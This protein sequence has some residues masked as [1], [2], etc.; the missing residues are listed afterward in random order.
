MGLN[1]IEI[2]IMNQKIYNRLLEIVK[3]YPHSLVDRDLL[4][5]LVKY[6]FDAALSCS[7]RSAENLIVLTNLIDDKVMTNYFGGVWKQLEG[8]GPSDEK[9]LTARI[10]ELKPRTIL[11]IG[12]GEN[13]LKRSFPALTGLDPYSAAADI[14][15]PLLD[16]TTGQKYDLVLVLGSINFGGIEKII[17]E[18]EKAIRLISERGRLIFRVNPGISHS[19]DESRWIDFFE[20]SP[21]FICNLGHGLGMKVE[22]L[23]RDRG[24]RIYFEWSA[25]KPKQ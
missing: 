19:S 5:L 15:K 3:D 6:E 20:W 12:C 22:R 25:L 24:G 23:E 9:R 16:Y 14:R 17:A 2:N 13:H 11:D 18:C 10:K 4:S 7:T 1:Q 21:S 8:D